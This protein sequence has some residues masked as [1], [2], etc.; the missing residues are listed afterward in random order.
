MTFGGNPARQRMAAPRG[1]LLPDD[2]PEVA[3]RAFWSQQVKSLF[4]FLI[5]ST[6]SLAH[7]RWANTEPVP[8][9]VKKACCGPDDA[10]HLRP[11]Q[12]QQT[13]AGWQVEGYNKLIPNGAELPSPDGT[14]WIFYRTFPDGSQTSAYCFFVPIPSM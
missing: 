7:D 9:W 5:L 14:Y 12:V 11:E 10:H 4:L 3:A 2:L 1:H 13:S 6:P 8:P